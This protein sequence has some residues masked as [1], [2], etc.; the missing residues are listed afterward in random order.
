MGAA[1]IIDFEKYKN[2]N[3]YKRRQTNKNG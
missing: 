2:K 3:L 1:K